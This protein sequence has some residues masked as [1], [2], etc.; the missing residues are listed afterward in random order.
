MSLRHERIHLVPVS[1]E[2][3]S[4]RPRFCHH[5]LNEYHCPSVENLNEAWV[6]DRYVEV[7]EPAIVKY[8]VWLT[9]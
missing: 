2:T 8:Y 4:M 5:C 9:C 6:A 7:V 1:T 3:D